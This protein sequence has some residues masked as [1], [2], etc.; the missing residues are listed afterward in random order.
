MSPEA[1]I[2]IV[3][4]ALL[5]LVAGW[6]FRQRLAAPAEADRKAL[7]E[8]VAALEEMRNAALRDLAVATDRA[9]QADDLRAR[10]EATEAA[11]ASVNLELA[12]H[13]AE[14]AARAESYEAQIRTINEAREALSLQ[15]SSTANKLL[16]EAEKRLTEQS[17]AQMRQ[18]H[19]KSEASLKALLQPV[20]STLK[21]YEEGLKG[22]EKERVDSYAALREAVEQVRTGQGQ[23][24]D[25]A[26]K[27]VN[28]L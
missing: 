2:A 9:G 22:V 20:E 8:R 27:L 18:A 26:A 24:R 12:A 11:R 13:K 25:E 17:G 19:E 1:L 4:A 16:A 28:A 6:L 3:V 7:A 23:V 15:F 14:A 10:L 5:G 21:R